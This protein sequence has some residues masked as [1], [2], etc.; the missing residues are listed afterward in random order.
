MTL[1]PD[2]PD[3][4]AAAAAAH[5]VPG[6]AIAIGF[7]GATVA[8]ASG[9]VNRNT[10]VEAT[11]DTVFQIG[12]VTKVWTA[13]LVMQLVDEG[14]V[15]LDQPV[16]RYLDTFA[17]VDR[18][19]TETVTVRQLL[20][21]TAGF[22]GDLFE[23]TGAGADA[24]DRYLEHLRDSATTLHPPGAMFSYCNAGYCVLGALV[25]RLRGTSWETALR[26]RLI[27]P[28]GATQMAIG[29]EEAILFRA[30]AGH[31]KP[32]GAADY[33]VTSRW[34]LPRSNGPAGATPCAAPG[35]LVKFGRLFLAGGVTADG[36]RLLSA[37]AIAA[38]RTPEVEM[39]GRAA[40]PVQQGLGPAL[41]DWSGTVLFGH[42]GG[43]I[44]QMTVWRVAPDHDLVVAANA[45]GGDIARSSTS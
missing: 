43:T 10:G 28:L 33:V 14:L 45:I 22:D 21:H 40:R 12:S 8:A 3:R 7:D 31:I 27:D 9:V 41:F 18:E 38:M 5:G 1:L 42:D 20:S 17:V 34:Q 36:T 44:G 39:P 6:A 2:L 4:I 15:D 19:L 26:K 37:D 29:A 16:R 25:A 11:P 23:D 32:D 24:L 13:A 30:A 35:D